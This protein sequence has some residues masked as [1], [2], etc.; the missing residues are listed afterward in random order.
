MTPVIAAIIKIAELS[1]FNKQIL[2]FSGL[3]LLA[4]ACWVPKEAGVA[5]RR[6]IAAL[7]KDLQSAQKG[8]DEQRAALHEDMDVAA[9]QTKRV[10]QKLQASYIHV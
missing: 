1:L 5:M 2:I 8:L 10:E 9:E 6:D 3:A 7:Y 4:S